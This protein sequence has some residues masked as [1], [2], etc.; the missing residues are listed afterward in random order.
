ML[1]GAFGYTLM[2]SGIDGIKGLC[3]LL[4]GIMSASE[5]LEFQHRQFGVPDIDISV[6]VGHGLLGIPDKRSSSAP[7]SS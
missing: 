3:P 1:D 7:A 2:S 5:P 4:R 6:N